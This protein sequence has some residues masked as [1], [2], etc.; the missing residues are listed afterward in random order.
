MSASQ[1]GL[2]LF[3]CMGGKQNVPGYE[4]TESYEIM[5][6]RKVQSAVLHKHVYSQLFDMGTK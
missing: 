4:T 3:A 5:N 6:T 1:A 2:V